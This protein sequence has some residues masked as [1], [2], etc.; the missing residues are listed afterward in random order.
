MST[1]GH[2]ALGLAAARLQPGSRRGLAPRLALYAFLGVAPDLDLVPI[3]LGW[4]RLVPLGH[5]GATHS[6]AAAVVVAAVVA[7]VWPGTSRLRTGLFA[8]LAMASHGLVDPLVAGSC[9]TALLWPFS[10]A[11]FTW[12]G[13]QPLPA[14]PV[15]PE[16]LEAYGFLHLAFEAALFAPFAVYALWPRSRRGVA[17]LRQIATEPLRA[18][19]RLLPELRSTSPREIRRVPALVTAGDGVRRAVRRT[20]TGRPRS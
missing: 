17:Q 7:L 6:L 3:A 1:V 16:L 9:G 4:G 11:P 19:R 20:G 12:G 2:L 15:G 8:F 14:T 13:F 18:G 5:R 10:D